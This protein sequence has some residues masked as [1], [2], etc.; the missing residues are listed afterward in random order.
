[1]DIEKFRDH[2]RS[3]ARDVLDGSSGDVPCDER[4]LTA[5]ESPLA[6]PMEVDGLKIGNRWVIHPMEG[7]D[8][9][10]DGRPGPLTIRRWKNFGESG[11]KLIWG[12]EAVAVEYSGRANPNQVVMAESTMAGIESLRED[13]LTACLLSTSPR[14]R[15]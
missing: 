13:L 2:L 9:E 15:D 3:V 4:I 6:A 5:P 7:W 12:G 11:A 14:P 10:S 8:G 1:M